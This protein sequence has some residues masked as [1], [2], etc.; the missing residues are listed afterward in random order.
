MKGCTPLD[1]LFGAPILE[2]GFLQQIEQRDWR[3]TMNELVE[4]LQKG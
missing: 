3:R 1:K 2:S 4:F